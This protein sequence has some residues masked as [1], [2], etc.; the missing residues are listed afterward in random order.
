V[1]LSE[2][3]V[4]AR[5]PAKV[6]LALRVLG[7][8]RDGYHEIRTVFQ[9][10]DLCDT[11]E[12]RPARD[13]CL[14][15]DEPDLPCDA[16]NLV[17]RAA[18]LLREHCGVGEG[19]EIRLRK[20]IP[21]GGGL[22]GGS[23]DAAGTLLALSA[24]W[25]LGLGIEALTP[26]AARLGADVPFFLHG[27]TAEGTGR[28]DRI[29]PIEFA[30]PRLL[31][32]GLPP[33]GVSTSEA[34]SWTDAH[35]TLPAKD[36][37]V[38]RSTAGKLPPE[39]DFRWGVNDLEGGVFERWPGLLAF[40]DDLLRGG[41]RLALLSGSGSTVFG[42]FDDSGPLRQAAESLAAR[43]PGWRLLPARAVPDAAHLVATGGPF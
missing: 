19:A 28:G 6:N 40:R 36:V 29:R 4:E 17:L 33:F 15:C 42:V 14:T 2:P 22:G 26:L 8:R 38:R 37:S 34:Y 27:G 43:Y 21:I 16:S 24:L 13:L 5:C 20:R 11:M 1:I 9:A 18:C 32:L 25:R 31:L 10:I 7:R 41:A 30:G 39:N 35:L 23:S 3:L 12:A